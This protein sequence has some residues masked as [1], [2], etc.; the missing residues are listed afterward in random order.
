MKS[1]YLIQYST[2]DCLDEHHF[3]RKRAE[4]KTFTD[5]GLNEYIE[6]IESLISVT[7]LGPAED[8]LGGVRSIEIIDFKSTIKSYQAIHNSGSDRDFL[9]YIEHLEL[10][11][12]QLVKI[13]MI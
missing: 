4:V 11:D 8:P 5:K 3:D 12:I 6:D 1:R 10:N 9:T 13:E 2:P 7:Y